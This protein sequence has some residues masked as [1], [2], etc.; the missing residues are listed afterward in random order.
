MSDESQNTGLMPVM[1][2]DE[3]MTRAS[4]LADFKTRV[5]K[6]DVD[7][8]TVPR[9]E[10][11][12]LFKAG[13]EKIATFLGLAARYEVTERVLDWTGEA[14]GG[15]PLF[16]VEHRCTLYRGHMAV[17]DGVGSCNTGEKKY[18]SKYS[19][20]L[21]DLINTVTKMSAKRSFIDA[22]IK[23]SN[24]SG[25]FTQDMEDTDAPSGDMVTSADQP[26]QPAPASATDEQLSRVL[27][28]VGNMG[29]R[30]E[31]LRDL[32]GR[33]FPEP[34]QLQMDAEISTLEVA[35]RLP[36]P[37]LSYYGRI[38]A[39]KRGV[40]GAEINTYMRGAFG[41]N[42]VSKLSR[43]QQT[44][45]ISW[46]LGEAKEEAPVQ[47]PVSY[48][49]EWEAFLSA[50]ETSVPF[51]REDIQAWV[52]ETYGRDSDVVVIDL[53]AVVLSELKA[54]DLESIR[55]QIDGFMAGKP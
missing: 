21:P 18:K 41:T 46:L 42:D 14:H 49:E 43:E 3:A 52:L 34:T 20:P 33:M 5:L 15:S 16:Y 38:L 26:R 47:G 8:G 1:T 50:L 25:V 6:R 27:E 48:Y 39:E 17:G 22:V 54:M 12:I 45:L 31:H 4:I 2:V 24:V 23:V 51:A 55:E 30:Q 28:L 11:D 32:M 13:A 29:V 53:P 10:G 9:V 7:Y 44:E 35:D 40:K 36:A 37:Y 19:P